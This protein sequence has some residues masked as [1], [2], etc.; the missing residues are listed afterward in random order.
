MQYKRMHNVMG[1]ILNL[2]GG[3][4]HSVSVR[5]ESRFCECLAFHDTNSI[6]ARIEVLRVVLKNFEIF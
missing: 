6:C 1:K 2:L 3:V 5:K 4:F